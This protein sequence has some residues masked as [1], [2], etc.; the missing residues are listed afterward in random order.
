[1]KN[2][3]LGLSICLAVAAAGCGGSPEPA[4]LLPSPMKWLVVLKTAPMTSLTSRSDMAGTPPGHGK[5]R[6][7][8]AEDVKE[9]TN[10]LEKLETQGC[11]KGVNFY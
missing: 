11:Q 7:V 1:M 3:A 2:L 5:W 9:K 6:S 8:L 10:I 4:E